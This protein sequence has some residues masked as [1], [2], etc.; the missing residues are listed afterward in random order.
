MQKEAKT[1][2]RLAFLPT[3]MNGILR[4]RPILGGEQGMGQGAGHGAQLPLWPPPSMF[5]PELS[6]PESRG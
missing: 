6:P 2:P 4:L 3:C 5:C 1:P